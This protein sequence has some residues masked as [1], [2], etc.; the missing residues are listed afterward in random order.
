M[1]KRVHV[2]GTS[3][4]RRACR[5]VRGTTRKGSMFFHEKKSEVREE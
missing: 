2:K 3:E 1:Q 4:D 5:D